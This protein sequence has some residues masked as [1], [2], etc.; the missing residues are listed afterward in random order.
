MPTASLLGDIEMAI[1][2][3]PYKNKEHFKR[4]FC[5]LSNMRQQNMLADVSVVAGNREIRAHRAILASASPYFYAMFTGDL[6]ESRQ[7]VVTLKEV[8]PNALE[9]LIEYCYTAEVPVNEDNVQV[10]LH[11]YYY[12]Q[13][14]TVSIYLSYC[15]NWEHYLN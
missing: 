10:D 4:A 6:S 8:D 14:I 2:V 1:P 3:P 11:Y 12:Y 7:E 9:L 13:F 5:V 15:A